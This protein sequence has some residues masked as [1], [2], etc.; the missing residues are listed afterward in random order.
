[1]LQMRWFSVYHPVT[2]P[3][4]LRSFRQGYP[5][6][7]DHLTS[8]AQA[9]C[10]QTGRFS[11]TDNTGSTEGERGSH[12]RTSNSSCHLGRPPGAGGTEAPGTANGDDGGS[13]GTGGAGSILY[14]PSSPWAT[15][16]S[17]TTG[18]FEDCVRCGGEAPGDDCDSE[19]NAGE[20]GSAKQKSLDAADGGH[21]SVGGYQGGTSQRTR[22][23]SGNVPPPGTLATE[24]GARSLGIAADEIEA[25]C[26]E[27][28]QQPEVSL[29]SPVNSEVGSGSSQGRVSGSMGCGSSSSSGSG[30]LRK[31]NKNKR[32]GQ[33]VSGGGGWTG[34]E[35]EG[36]NPAKIVTEWENEIAKNILSLYQ[37]KLKADLDGKKN[38]KGDDLVVSLSRNFLPWRWKHYG[39]L[40]NGAWEAFVFGA[41]TYKGTNLGNREKAG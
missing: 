4:N 11:T 35:G 30:A 27:G 8:L 23:D 9:Y 24:I 13:G 10:G 6:N 34:G 26:P 12:E 2:A 15:A 29:P 38:A 16:V 33:G 39:I 7:T 18:V 14:A 37:T 25:R 40:G 1:M 17:S 32:Q 41:P 20:E 19:R 31:G 5:T 36:D 3:D 28:P 21:Q 22:R